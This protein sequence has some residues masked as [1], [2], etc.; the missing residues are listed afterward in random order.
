MKFRTEIEI[1]AKQ[2]LDITHNSS[3]VMLGSCFTDN[4][5]EMLEKDGF[6]VIHNPMGP[7][8]NP[9]SLARA[10]SL[11]LS[12]EREL[13]LK[14]DNNGLWHCL[15]FAT[16]YTCED[17]DNLIAKVNSD[18]DLLANYIK[19]CTTLI[20]TLGTA[21]VF[22]LQDNTVVGNCHKFPSSDFSRVCLTV[23][24]VSGYISDIVSMITKSV[25]LIF[26]V[27]PIRHT[28]DTL[29]GNQLSKA[30][31]QLGIAPHISHQIH[32]FPA[33]EIM[34][35]DLRDYRFY[36]D[37]LKHPS[38]MAVEYIYEKFQQ[39]YMTTKTIGR[40]LV[41][42]KENKRTSHRKILTEIK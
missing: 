30:T 28:A 42:R 6:K 25:N 5:G 31:L 10:I 3:I 20:I 33:Y 39:Y 19:S 18:L 9:A 29:H 27:S 7:L 37:D 12:A 26:T 1:P 11:A 17:K 24:E 36:A 35:D 34:L 13:T 2:H 41:C 40:G 32:Y 23:G 8:Y 4:V 21:F 14:E 22:Q 15:D 38:Q 16:R